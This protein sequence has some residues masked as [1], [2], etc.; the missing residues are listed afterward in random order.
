MG[1]IY[2]MDS[3]TK[4]VPNVKKY[5][6]YLFD[7]N[8]GKTPIMLSGLTD[9]GKVHIAY[10]TKFY[11]DKPICIITYNDMQAKKI[12]K[13]FGFFD[14]NI[15]IF[16]KR[17]V[18]SFDYIAESKDVLYERISNINDI[19]ENK[20]PIIITTIEAV[21]QKMISKKDL[22]K[23]VLNIKVND[24]ISIDKL[25]ENLISLRI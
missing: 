2:N 21:M 19:M 18:A 23:N 3:L 15:K 5:S 13:D 10:S 6:D 11:T 16:P 24:E 1:A 17:D 25:K 12:K 8:K 20:A 4:I 7:I 14:D 22:Y 9:T